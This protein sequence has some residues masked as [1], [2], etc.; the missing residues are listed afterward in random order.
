MVGVDVDVGLL[1]EFSYD[2]EIGGLVGGSEGEREAK[3]IAKRKLL[4]HGIPSM[5]FSSVFRGRSVFKGLFEPNV[6]G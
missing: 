2:V 6:G 1:G 4:L 5:D 3:A